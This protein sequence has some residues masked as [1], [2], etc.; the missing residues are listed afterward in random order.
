[1][2]LEQLSVLNMQMFRTLLHRWGSWA[3]HCFGTIPVSERH[4]WP[5]LLTSKELL[6]SWERS[7]RTGA[8]MKWQRGGV[9]P[10]WRHLCSNAKEAWSPRGPG[11]L[12]IALLWWRDGWWLLD[13]FSRACYDIWGWILAVRLGWRV[14]VGGK[15]REQWPPDLP[16][17]IHWRWCSMH[18]KAWQTCTQ[19]KLKTWN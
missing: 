15:K 13:V 11:E 18:E 17:I 1:M 14:R 6:G 3:N 12:K 19:R 9:V 5:C 2:R 16:S 7:R 4:S 10:S 8:R